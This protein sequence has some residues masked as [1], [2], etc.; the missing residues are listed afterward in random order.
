MYSRKNNK[1]VLAACVVVLLN[2]SSCKKYEDGPSLSLKSKN[3]RLT[4]E[5]EVDEIDNVSPSVG[6]GGT[7]ILEF[8]KDGDFSYTTSYSYDGASY[9]YSYEGEWEWED[10]KKS[11]EI[12]I[13]S[14]DKTEFEILKLTNKEFWFEDEDGQEWHC[15]KD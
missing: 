8:E 11:V 4:G 1:L 15:E 13:D 2:L 7:M 10:G 3:S 6:F 14:E 5:W 12:D 9:S